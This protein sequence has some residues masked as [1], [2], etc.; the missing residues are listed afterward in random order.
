VSNARTDVDAVL[1][2]L[3]LLHGELRVLHRD[4]LLILR[5]AEELWLVRFSSQLK[6]VIDL[7][8]REQI[9]SIVHAKLLICVVFLQDYGMTI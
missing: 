3:K 6:V 2:I 7:K 4:S 8:A 5:D 1:D 9:W